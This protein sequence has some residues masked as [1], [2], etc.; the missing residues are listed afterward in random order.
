M[1]VPGYWL[2]FPQ[3]HVLFCLLLLLLTWLFSKNYFWARWVN[4]RLPPPL[5]FLCLS[6]SVPL[7]LLRFF[8]S[9]WFF[10]TPCVRFCLFSLAP[11]VLSS[12]SSSSSPPPL[13]LLGAPLATFS[14]AS[15]LY[16]HSP[17]TRFRARILW[18]LALLSIC[19]NR[20][21][22]GSEPGFCDSWPC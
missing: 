11:L 22:L 15:Q 12:S 4:A 21:A 2:L 9:L 1:R 19:Y 10:L 13:L 18:Q 20:P 5:V 8:L 17:R 7:Q 3:C 6:V 16:R 14:R